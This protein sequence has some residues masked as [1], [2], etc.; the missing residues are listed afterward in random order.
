[1]RATTCAVVFVFALFSTTGCEK[2]G[3]GKSDK[4]G[5]SD[6]GAKGGGTTASSEGDGAKPIE[7][8]KE[9]RALVK[10]TV[11]G[12]A[13]TVEIPGHRLNREERKGDATL[14][15]YVTWSSKGNP[16]E[17][18][19]FTVQPV[20]EE[21]YPSSLESLKEGGLL[22]PEQKVTLAEALPGGGYLVVV[23]ETS[24]QYLHVKAYRKNAAGKALRF[25]ITE[26]RS[27]GI[28]SFDAEKAWAI[29]V[30]KTLTMP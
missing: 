23:V 27:S 21:L 13:F 18:P 16:F 4:S 11:D 1:M 28:P 22:M 26:R 3:G 2:D 30:A 24:K 14:P 20:P 5:A 12:I 6:Q 15:G 8:P 9:K 17:A 7:W 19:G 29:A 10:D 25:S